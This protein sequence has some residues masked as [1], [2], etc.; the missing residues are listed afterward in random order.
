M[1]RRLLLHE[2]RSGDAADQAVLPVCLPIADVAAPQSGFASDGSSPDEMGVEGG[3][4][5]R[6]CASR[7]KS[8]RTP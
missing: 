6:R 2:H 3:V 1:A 7:G 5:P 8:R 4:V